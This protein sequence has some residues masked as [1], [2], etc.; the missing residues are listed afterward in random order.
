MRYRARPVE[1]EAMR[2]MTP[3]DCYHIS[4]EFPDIELHN[5]MRGTLVWDYLQLTWVL[6]NP[7]D[8]VIK[9]MRGEYYP[10]AADVFEEK[11]EEVE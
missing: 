2:Y 5:D 10:C 4:K 1:I 3:A 7:G 8:Y 9:G 11:Y 6:V